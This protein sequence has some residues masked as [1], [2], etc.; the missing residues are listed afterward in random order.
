MLHAEIFLGGGFFRD[1]ATHLPEYGQQG[2]IGFASTRRCR[3]EKTPRAL[4]SR[5]INLTLDLVEV[6]C[7]FE[8]TLCV[9]RQRR[10]GHQVF[11]GHFCFRGWC[12]RNHR[13]II[14][15]CFCDVVFALSL[16]AIHADLSHTGPVDDYVLIL[17]VHGIFKQ[18]VVKLDPRGLF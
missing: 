13:P 3:N 2:D 6:F 1:E 7:G 12:N 17:L 18:V 15:L 5:L 10:N 8:G 9:S 14:S 4:E 16:L 11:L